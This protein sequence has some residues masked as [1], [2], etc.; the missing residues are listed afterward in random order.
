[1]MNLPSRLLFDEHWGQD[2]DQ[3]P[4]DPGNLRRIAT[5]AAVCPPVAS[6]LEVGYGSGD[7]LA[8]LATRAGA[9][10]GCDTSAVGLR[11][12]ARR[13]PV[14]VVQAAADHLPFRD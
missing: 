12:A 1:M 14:Q 4:P 10:F 2:P 5:L 11:A 8:V 3:A 6:L 13:G 9:R 7:V